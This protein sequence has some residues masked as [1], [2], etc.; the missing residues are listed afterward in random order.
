MLKI[1]PAKPPVTEVV[2]VKPAEPRKFILELN[3]QQ[4]KLL[5]AIQARLKVDTGFL[6]YQEWSQLDDE[7]FQSSYPTSQEVKKSRSGL[8][9][10]VKYGTGN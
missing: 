2:L 3:E 6:S 4:M 7:F 5:V 9:R 1:I 10:K 8:N